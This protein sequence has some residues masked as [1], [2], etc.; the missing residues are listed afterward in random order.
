MQVRSRLASP[1][2]V[3]RTL[4]GVALALC[5]LLV[6]AP[7]AQAGVISAGSG[8]SSAFVLIQFKNNNAF[9][10]EVG[11]TG[12]T[13]S[14]IGLLDALDSALG[15][16]F[17]LDAPDV[18]PFGRFVDGITYLTN[19]NSGFGGGEDWWHYWVWD[20]DNNAWLSPFDFGASTRVVNDGDRDAWV[21]GSAEA[22]STTLI[23]EPTAIILLVAGV[24]VILLRRRA[25]R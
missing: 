7:Q 20:F 12:P 9:A 25:Q 2:S 17:T 8:D 13:T 1:S 23:P 24:P 5:L 16:S 19:T 14:G 21:Y 22:P 15:G 18:P 11:Y 4:A 3:L 10:F 6:A